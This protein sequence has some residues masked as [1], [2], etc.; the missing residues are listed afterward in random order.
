MLS[1]V[2]MASALVYDWC[3]APPEPQHFDTVNHHH[4]LDKAKRKQ[5]TLT[6]GHKDEVAT[7]TKKVRRSES[8]VDASAEDG[9]LDAARE[10]EEVCVIGRCGTAVRV[11]GL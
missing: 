5:N 8:V 1:L 10:L 9:D 11:C 4:L 7:A 2:T 6:N 3:F